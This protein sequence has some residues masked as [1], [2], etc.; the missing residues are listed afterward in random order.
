M[1]T[2]DWKETTFIIVMIFFG[3][4][5]GLGIYFIVIGRE[6]Y[7]LADSIENEKVKEIL[8]KEGKWYVTCGSIILLFSS[9]ALGYVSYKYF[10]EKHIRKERMEL[11]HLSKDTLL[12]YALNNTLETDS[13]CDRILNKEGL[14][15][16]D[17][18]DMTNK[19]ALENFKKKYMDGKN[20]EEYV[21]TRNKYCF[22]KIQEIL[23]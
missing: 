20:N 22:N 15:I 17:R 12:K 11:I 10:K 4:F 1:I 2:Q 9:C 13:N 16:K 18:G 6:R 23:L 14:S 21:K 7:S 3:L 8:N 19:E 5:L